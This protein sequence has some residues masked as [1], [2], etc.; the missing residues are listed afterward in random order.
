MDLIGVGE[1]LVSSCFR[2]GLQQRPTLLENSVDFDQS[3]LCHLLALRTLLEK[4]YKGRNRL[5][6]CDEKLIMG[7]I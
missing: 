5:S 6:I 7:L 2:G 3:D 1:G 4:V